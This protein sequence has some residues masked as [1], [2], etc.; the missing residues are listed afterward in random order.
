MELARL[1][2]PQAGASCPK[3]DLWQARGLGWGVERYGVPSVGLRI[4]PAKTILVQLGPT[5]GLSGRATSAKGDPEQLDTGHHSPP[6]W[7]PGLWGWR[8]SASP[9]PGAWGLS[10]AAVPST[11]HL[12]KALNASGGGLWALTGRQ[13]IMWACNSPQPSPAPHPGRS[14]RSWE[15]HHHT[16]DQAWFA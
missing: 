3:G 14:P 1:L 4:S 15:E 12:K 7:S 13:D 10:P 6:C 5:E 11:P 8:C 9:T 16:G 2:H